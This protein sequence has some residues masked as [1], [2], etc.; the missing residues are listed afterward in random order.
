MARVGQF[1]ALGSALGGYKKTLADVQSKDYA[2]KYADVR[3]QEQ[4]S[5]Y[6]EIG[7]TVA[8]IIGI[9]QEMKALK[10][11]KPLDKPDMPKVGLDESYAGEMKLDALSDS[12]MP[13]DMQ[14]INMSDSFLDGSNPFGK[15]DTPSE[16]KMEREVLK[17]SQQR[18]PLS[19]SETEGADAQFNKSKKVLDETEALYTSE[20]NRVQNVDK[21]DTDI[22]MVSQTS[23][24]I[25]DVVAEDYQN[26]L[27]MGI[28]PLDVR[29]DQSSIQ[30]ETATVPSDN[31][32]VSVEDMF[33][34]N[35][36]KE[37]T[38]SVL[39]LS[40]I[41]E[42]KN[43]SSFER[44]IA[45][46]ENPKY[47]MGDDSV[48]TYMDID[49]KTGKNRP[50]EGYGVAKGDTTRTRKENNQALRVNIN[51]AKKG[52]KKIVGNKVFSKLPEQKQEVLIELI[53]QMGPTRIQEFPNF[54]K[55]MVMGDFNLAANEL[56][57]TSSGEP[58][59][60]SQKGGKD[61]VKRIVNKLRKT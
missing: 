59:D 41:E 35:A 44:E 30:T 12:D 45:M 32:S 4:V 39:N 48:S 33:M 23:S 40:N 29:Q 42:N 58:S 56:L 37:D 47:F 15:L 34:N 5:L 18:R 3:A 7:G 22:S 49:T 46:S 27:N 9:S 16:L 6:N 20:I 11:L 26:L 13:S 43:F 57:F 38:T 2:K 51:E 53:Y 61:R 24:A 8:N 10:K 55:A 54:L 60:W 19:V 21:V 1:K 14:E 28:V 25:S 36:T 50:A 17:A 52:A 31:T